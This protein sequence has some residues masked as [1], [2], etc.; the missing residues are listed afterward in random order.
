MNLYAKHTL[1]VEGYRG[2]FGKCLITKYNLDKDSFQKHYVIGIKELWKI[3]R[4]KLK[5]C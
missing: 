1:I 2:H 3:D 4:V 5:P